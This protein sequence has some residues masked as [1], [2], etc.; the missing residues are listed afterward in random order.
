MKRRKYSDYSSNRKKMQSK[1]DE[2][3]LTAYPTAAHFLKHENLNYNFQLL[4]FPSYSDDDYEPSLDSKG[5]REN[6]S[7]ISSSS[8][9]FSDFNLQEYNFKYI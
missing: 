1:R 9:S 7:P 3:E 5:E 8:S 2:M 6:K 4:S